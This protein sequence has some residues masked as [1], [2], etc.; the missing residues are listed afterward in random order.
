M[1]SFFHGWRRKVGVVTLVVACAFTAGWVRSSTN[2]DAL[3][4]GF[5]KRIFWIESVHGWVQS[6][7]ASVKTGGVDQYFITPNTFNFAGKTVKNANH[8]L[9]GEFDY[10]SETYLVG[11]PSP[12]VPNPG[13]PVSTHQTRVKVPY[14]SIAIPL[15]L[16]SAWLLL[17]KPRA[18]KPTNETAA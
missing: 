7:F 11:H 14:W 3:Q 12:F 10:K 8:P 1:Q 16:L 6:T 5:G 2:S 15:T 13:P 4:V 17:S 9:L 18:A